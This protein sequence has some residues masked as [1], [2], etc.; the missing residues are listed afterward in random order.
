[1]ALAEPRDDRAVLFRIG[2]QLAAIPI[3]HVVEIMRTLPI[4]A[5][6]DLPRGVLGVSRIRGEVVPVV[7]GSIVL[8]GAPGERRAK[9]IL[10]RAGDRRVALAVDEVEG[11]HVLSREQRR[12]L[13]PLLGDGKHA[14][15][16]A[17]H[18]RAL[19]P[20]LDDVRLVSDEMYR[21]ISAAAGSGAR[22]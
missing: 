4:D 6:A 8:N 21:A 2:A 20:V 12:A 11:V 22:A 10:L 18:D 9:L 15:E 1:M 14:R 7:D 16:I 17:V 3:G 13:P 5:L 19:V